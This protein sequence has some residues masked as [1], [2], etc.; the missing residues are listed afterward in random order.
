ME[1]V[2]RTYEGPATIGGL[3]LPEV[4]IQEGVNESDQSWD[5]SAPSVQTR[6]WAGEAC[7]DDPAVL[8]AV[9]GLPDGPVEVVL[10]VGRAAAAFLT[11]EVTQHADQIDPEWQIVLQGT[12]PS[13]LS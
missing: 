11:I 7:G 13:P 4:L 2:T 6:W 5:F 8:R 3:S 1:T 10:S 12:G 9:W